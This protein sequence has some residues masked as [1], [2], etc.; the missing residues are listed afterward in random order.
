LS[1]TFKLI[2]YK[3]GIN[4]FQSITLLRFTYKCIITSIESII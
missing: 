3:V 1:I 2:I 4:L